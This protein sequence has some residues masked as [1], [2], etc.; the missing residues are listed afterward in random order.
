MSLRLRCL[1]EPVPDPY[2]IV[3]ALTLVLVALSTAPRGRW[4]MVRATGAGRAVLVSCRLEMWVCSGS[5]TVAFT[6]LFRLAVPSL[7]APRAL[8]SSADAGHVDRVVQRAGTA[9]VT[10]LVD[11]PARWTLDELSTQLSAVGDPSP[12]KL[13]PQP[14]RVPLGVLRQAA[15]RS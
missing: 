15:D 10:A 9:R 8:P 7:G 5:M 1:T 2:D 13:H 4:S 6:I 11:G 14:E 12:H 3:P